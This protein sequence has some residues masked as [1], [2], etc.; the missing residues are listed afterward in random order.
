M[1]GPDQVVHIDPHRLLANPSASPAQPSHY[2]TKGASPSP[3][4]VADGSSQSFSRCHWWRS[5]NSRSPRNHCEHVGDVVESDAAGL[6]M[7]QG[8]EGRAV[9]RAR[10]SH[11][12]SSRPRPGC[13]VARQTFCLGG[14]RNRTDTVSYEC[15]DDRVRRRTARGLERESGPDR[16][17]MLPLSVFSAMTSRHCP[18][19]TADPR[20]GT[21]EAE[22]LMPLAVGVGKCHERARWLL[23]QPAQ[24]HAQTLPTGHSPTVSEPRTLLAPGGGRLPERS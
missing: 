13:R 18:G 24:V 14:R 12:A 10:R 23:E 21:T 2:G 17:T 16:L 5:I 15:R 22:P 8:R 6:K 9:A 4:P 1:A 11:R 7:A 20:S 3:R 19:G